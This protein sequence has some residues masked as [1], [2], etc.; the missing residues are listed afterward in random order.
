MGAKSI[1]VFCTSNSISR[2]RYYSLR[3]EGLGPRE[4]SNGARV[5]ITDDAEAEWQMLMEV[6][7]A[8]VD[9]AE[10]CEEHNVRA[11][12]QMLFPRSDIPDTIWRKAWQHAPRERAKREQREASR[13]KVI[14]DRKARRASALPC[15]L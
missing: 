9:L 13:R 8:I 6:L 10:G 4:M 7:T 12:V 2:S 5:T 11:A 15:R 1:E 14:E 3:S